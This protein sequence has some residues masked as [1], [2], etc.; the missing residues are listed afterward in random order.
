MSADSRNQAAPI[1][2]L[3]IRVFHTSLQKVCFRNTVRLPLTTISRWPCCPVFLLPESIWI[4]NGWDLPTSQRFSN[5]SILIPFPTPISPYLYFL[6]PSSLRPH[7]FGRPDT[8]SR[9]SSFLTLSRRSLCNEK[10][11]DSRRA[12][13]SPKDSVNRNWLPTIFCWYLAV[14]L[15]K[16]WET[17]LCAEENYHIEE[18]LHAHRVQNLAY[19][20]HVLKNQ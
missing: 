10:R 7:S 19:C 18:W 12:D 11:M 8:K 6:P 5:A 17:E 1:S 20:L 14:F 4:S 9:L 3:A 13:W 16:D 15:M 2:E